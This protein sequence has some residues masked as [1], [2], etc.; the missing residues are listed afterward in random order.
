M[1]RDLIDRPA[2]DF[3]PSAAARCRLRSA[4]PRR[5]GEAT[6]ETR[7]RVSVNLS[8]SPLSWLKARRLVGGAGV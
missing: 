7:Q 1:D 2:S 5:R 8:E 4:H 3:G 6:S